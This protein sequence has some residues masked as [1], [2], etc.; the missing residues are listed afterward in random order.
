M[1]DTSAS[2]CH[3]TVDSP[4][5]G[6]I[7]N[8]LATACD[9]ARSS[10]PGS[11][12]PH[13]RR[14][15]RSSKAGSSINEATLGCLLLCLGVGSILA[16]VSSG[17]IVSRFGCRR[18]INVSMVVAAV[19]LGL[20]GSVDGLLPDR[21]GARI[22]WRRN[23]NDGRCNECSRYC[24]RTRLGTPHD[25]GLSRALQ[26]RRSCGRGR[27]SGC[28]VSRHYAGRYGYRCRIC[29]HH[30]ARHF[31]SA[32]PERQEPGTRFVAR[33]PARERAAAR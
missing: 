28:A 32:F 18:V 3:V 8:S 29:A 22:V 33:R 17:S 24:C 20:L 5:P 21:L 31:R 25:V 12:L 23:R 13:G 15:S 16:M 11:Q 30:C 6:I 9:R 27:C 7:R 19:M 26:Y 14:W 1:C 10:R 4:M 2:R